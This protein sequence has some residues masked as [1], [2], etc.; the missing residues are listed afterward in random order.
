MPVLCTRVPLRLRA[1]GVT[2]AALGRHAGRGVDCGNLLG[3]PVSLPK[4]IPSQS[5]YS[6][7][8]PAAARAGASSAAPRLVG[9]KRGCSSARWSTFLAACTLSMARNP[10]FSHQARHDPRPSWL[11]A[12]ELSQYPRPRQGNMQAAHAGL[13]SRVAH[14]W[15]RGLGRCPPICWSAVAWPRK[16]PPGVSSAK[17]SSLRPAHDSSQHWAQV[18]VPD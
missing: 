2:G 14:S 3:F 10:Q 18:D 7:S 6:Y 16:A 11:R 17:Y 13:C 4:L 15:P 8:L 1:K 9:E 5:K 12:Q